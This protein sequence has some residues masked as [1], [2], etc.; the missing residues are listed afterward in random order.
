M[1]KVILAITFLLF[2]GCCF[3]TK[4]KPEIVGSNTCVMCH[5]TVETEINK[6]PHN[7]QNGVQCEDC[8]G[9][10]SKHA[11]DPSPDNIF[12][13][14]NKSTRSIFKKCFKCHGDMHKN[15]SSHFLEGKSCLNCHDTWHSEKTVNEFPI[16]KPNLLKDGSAALCFKCHITQ[17][18]EFARPFHHQFSGTGNSCLRCHNPHKSRKEIRP[19]QMS[20][21]C[22]S[23]HPDTSG[24]FVY[25]HLGTQHNGCLE[26]HKPHGSTN[27]NLLIR[28]NTRFLC[29]SCHADTPMFHNQADPK[30]KN[31]TS[32]HSAIHGS[33]VSPKFFE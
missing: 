24:P 3:A 26:C 21:K 11:D 8:H 31:C 22:G 27:P 32:C 19:R 33:N 4:T 2:T 14:K 30:Y 25:V 29:L 16:P 9:P 17:K 20:Q 5:D 23:C 6:T 12:N 18:I 7:P 1:K 10:G 13:F 15:W 28:N